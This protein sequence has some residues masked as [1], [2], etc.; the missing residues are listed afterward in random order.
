MTKLLRWTNISP[1]SITEIENEIKKLPL[2]KV[3]EL[4][5]WFSNYHAEIWDRRIEDDLRSGR[6]DD[7]L[8]E[9]DQEIDAG[10][11]EPL[12][13]SFQIA[14]FAERKSSAFPGDPL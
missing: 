2:E 9:V 7:L 14:A 11:A 10:L 13:L 12:Q 1:I 4:I 8:T 5:T 3:D 6:L